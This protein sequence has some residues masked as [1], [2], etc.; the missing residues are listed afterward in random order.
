MTG[1]N[2]N[3]E[4][5]AGQA[6]TVGFRRHFGYNIPFLIKRFGLH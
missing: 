2:D 6:A 3:A 1:E 5:K 4:R